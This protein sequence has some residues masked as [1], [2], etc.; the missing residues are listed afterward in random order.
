MDALLRVL[1][2]NAAAA[3]LLAV[4]G[5]PRLALVR[6]P[7]VAHGLWLLALAE[8]RDAAGRAA[9]ARPARG[10]G[11]MRPPEAPTDRCSLQP[12]PDADRPA[13]SDRAAAGEARSAS[14][15]RRGRASCRSRPRAAAARGRR[16][17]RCFRRAP[18]R[19][20]PLRALPPAAG[21][22][23]CRRPGGILRREAE[24]AQALGLRRVPPV[25]LVPA[26]IPP[27]LWP[28]RDGAG[29]APAA[30]AVAE[31]TLDGARRAARSRAR[32][33]A[34]ARP[35]GAA[36]GA[37][38]DGPLLVVPVTWW[39]RARAAPRRGALLRRVGAARAAPVGAGLCQRPAQEPDVRLGRCDT[40][41]SFASGASPLYEL[42]TRLKEILMSRPAPRLSAPLRVALLAAAGLGLA[43]FPT[44]A[45]NDEPV[46][47]AQ[48]AAA[49]RPAEAG[50]RP[51][52]RPPRRAR[53][54]RR[55]RRPVG[56]HSATGD[57]SG[58]T[59]AGGSARNGSRAAER[60][61]RGRRALARGAAAGVRGE[62]TRPPASGARA[63][64]PGDR[65]ACARGAGRGA[66]LRREDAGRGQDGA[67]PRAAS[68]TASSR[69]S[70]WSWSSTARAPGPAARA[71]CESS[72]PRSWPCAADL[73]RVSEQG[74]REAQELALKRLAEDRM[75]SEDEMIKRHARSK[76]RRKRSRSRRESSSHC[77]ASRWSAPR[78]R[79]S[80]GRWPT[81][82][83]PG[84]PRSRTTR[85]R[86]PSSSA[87]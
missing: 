54:L 72:S 87:R 68:G 48:P 67:R 20:D 63:A 31:L 39:A 59:R 77:S 65:A 76:A 28:E 35:L 36:A 60:D 18:A 69:A 27:M 24:L 14:C 19:R 73:E 61:E 29:A 55:R 70:A 26:R 7:A 47:T 37:R 11:P 25:R 53:P 41:P 4:A 9:A 33:R 80:R 8:A 82:S 75:R 3:G 22:A 6:R 66:R 81:R 17:G 46:A 2:T 1:L 32:A 84:R 5:L 15:Q 23:P 64:A 13:A 62:A 83:K 16:R 49:V 38:G 21:C 45:R 57:G 51:A 40:V 43:V 50:R 85:K 58:D 78:P 30:R 56:R 74:G 79:S 12:Q 52:R 86:G 44:L 71:R 10:D 42:E 34:A